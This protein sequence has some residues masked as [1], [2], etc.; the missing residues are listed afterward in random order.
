MYSLVI[1]LTKLHNNARSYSMKVI[2]DSFNII[3][4]FD[5]VNCFSLKTLCYC[6]KLVD[7]VTDKV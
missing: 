3:E 6:S 1:Y 2:L 4:C 7:E 5:Y